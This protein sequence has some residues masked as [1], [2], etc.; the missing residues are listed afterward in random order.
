MAEEHGPQ[1]LV[2]NVALAEQA[3]FDHLILT[4]I[5]PDQQGVMEFFQATL[6]PALRKSWRPER[7]VPRQSSDHR[8]SR[9]W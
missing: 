3:G 7:E 4:Q 1:A 6:A 5:G 2:H 9:L 8:R